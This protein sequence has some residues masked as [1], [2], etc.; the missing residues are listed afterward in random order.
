M[1][2]RTI[3]EKMA[4][5]FDR[6]TR[7]RG[8]EYVRSNRITI[9]QGSKYAI[10]GVAR[11][12]QEYR[13]TIRLDGADV[14]IFCG[15]E[16]YRKFGPCK[17]LWAAAIEAE[18]LGFLSEIR[19]TS[20]ELNLEEDRDP[21]ALPGEAVLPNWRFYLREIDAKAPYTQAQRPEE[22]PA[23][24]QILYLIDPLD[25]LRN[26]RAVSLQILARTP[27]RKSGGWNRTSPLRLSHEQLQA[28]PPGEDREILL[29][30]AGSRGVVSTF[31][32]YTPEDIPTAYELTAALGHK[33]LPVLCGTGRCFLKSP[34]SE[35]RF[36]QQPLAWDP[37]PF[38]FRLLWQQGGDGG[39]QVSSEYCREDEMLALDASTQ[40]IAGAFLLRGH[41]LGPLSA[42][43]A[44]PWIQFFRVQGQIAISAADTD[45]FVRE[46]MKRLPE[47]VLHLPLAL[48]YE[49]VAGEPH[50]S[51]KLRQAQRR[52]EQ[53]P[54]TGRPEFVYAEGVVA[55]AETQSEVLFHPAER[56][57]IERDLEAERVALQ[58]LTDA[59]FRPTQY[60]G[61][62]G[63]SWDI[64]PGKLL[65]AL[66]RLFQAG[67][68]VEL[69]GLPMRSA[70]KMNAAVSTGIDWFELTGEVQF[71]DLSVPLPQLLKAMQQGDSMFK[72][73]DGSIAILDEGQ[74]GRLKS[75]L[76]LADIEKGQVRFQRNQVALLDALLASQP[77]IAVD[78]KL[79]HAREELRNFKGIGMAEQP[80]GF[81]GELR[82]YQREGLGW[83]QFLNRFQFGGCL[84]DD[85]G[86]GKTAQVLAL[87]ETRRA[88]RA[89][90]EAIGP[91]LVVAPRSLIFNWQREAARFTPQMRTLDFTG[92][93]RSLEQIGEVDV[94]L[95][96]YGTLRRDIV[97]LQSQPFD[98]VILDEAQAIKNFGSA[99]AKAARLLKATHRLTMTGTP[100]ENHLGELWSLFEFLNPGM[101]GK[102]SVLRLSG[103]G[104]RTV[105]PETRELLAAG[106]RP[107]LLRRTKEQVA[108]E[109]PAK[110]EQ[111]LFCELE[112]DERKLYNELRDHYRSS[113]L[114]GNSRTWNKRKLQVLEA[115]LRLRQASC[116]PGLVDKKRATGS[117][118]K[119]DTLLSQLEE[120]LQE[121]HKALI[122]SQFTSLLA[123]V[124]AQLDAQGATYEYLDGKT[125][126]RQAPVERFQTDPDCKLFLI[127]LKAGGVGL[128][129]TA[130][131][132]VFLL[133]PWWNPAV[134]AQA[135]DRTHRIGQDKPV[136]AYRLIAKD[137]VEERVLEL[138]SSK[139]EL[140]TAI[141]NEDNAL[142]SNLKPEDLELL[143][144]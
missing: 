63:Q 139:R 134:E 122:F 78:A 99:S 81:T 124:R 59:G 41:T 20:L 115:L 52:M 104:S 43:K 79:E 45:E 1:A 55:H 34:A 95:T 109:L 39:W 130:A 29:S 127:S 11:G 6:E 26:A 40:I 103:A 56:K 75:L 142:V 12:S 132:Y 119:L 135:I 65:P 128:N 92:L 85:M 35:D 14:H 123:L 46:A 111:T 13:F 21:D 53:D 25:T 83:L 38:S 97:T 4:V 141:L 8:W 126:D 22:R 100:V 31:A 15:C 86:V 76:Q 18:R 5:F 10:K 94:I 133:D 105:A 3:A 117:S 112:P 125:R 9:R 84:A 74:L 144:S 98:Y 93:G 69:Q 17:H 113:L 108:R 82:G 42:A 120:V 47:A 7:N 72:L 137:T 50:P 121:G 54:F 129:L 51:L 96:T 61:V 32:T 68:Y 116:H 16:A 143:L 88:A 2:A 118:T 102:A 33:L 57:L 49:R 37:E 87:L 106:L 66:R 91:S 23:D 67:W 136:F 62:E 36:L 110:V 101:L 90:G 58:V 138:Q 77:E 89:A 107:F 19:W 73:D 44:L 71:D 48:R 131:D 30:L 28:M 114:G 140:A 80:A 64:A 27:N 24:E 70:T 60:V